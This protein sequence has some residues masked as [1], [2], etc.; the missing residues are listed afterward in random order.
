MCVFERV[1]VDVCLC[2]QVDNVCTHFPSLSFF[3]LWSCVERF[4]PDPDHLDTYVYQQPSLHFISL[5]HTILYYVTALG[6]STL[7]DPV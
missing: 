4:T 3:F 7:V 5:H 1:C 2:V 6:T